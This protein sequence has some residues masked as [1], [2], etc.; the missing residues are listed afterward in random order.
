MY[1]VYYVHFIHNF[2]CTALAYVPFIVLYKTRKQE[3]MNR[4]TCHSTFIFTTFAILFP[5]VLCACLFCLMSPNC[6]VTVFFL[7]YKH[8]E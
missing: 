6:G 4:I 3:K 8:L 2:V 1:I 5:F 7:L